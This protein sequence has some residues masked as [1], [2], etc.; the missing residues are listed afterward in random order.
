MP[1]RP[2]PSA[3][4]LAL[5]F[6][7]AG[8][9]LAAAAGATTIVVTTDADADAADGGCSLREAILAANDD[10]A[11]NECPAGDGPDRIEFSLTLPEIIVLT[12]HLP[13]I[14]GT[15]AI[16]GPGATLLTVDGDTTFRPLD[17]DSPG[18]D[19]WLLVE[20]LAFT[21]GRTPAG[22]TT[23]GG[24]HIGA[25]DT[26]T[27][28]RVRFVGNRAE[29]GGGGLAVDSH[30]AAQS[31]TTLVDCLVAENVAEGPAGG[32]GLFTG[33]TG[34]VVRIVGTTFFANEAAHPNGPGGGLRT[35]RAVVN[36]LDSTLT[37]NLA[38]GPGGGLYVS[39]DPIGGSTLVIRNT[40]IVDNQAGTQ[41]SSG[42]GGGLSARPGPDFPLDLLIQ[43]TV[44]AENLD[45]TGVAPDLDCGPNLTTLWASGSDFVGSDAGCEALFPPGEPNAAGDF[46]GT[47]TAPLLPLLEILAYHGGPTPTHRPSV[48]P[49]SP[50]ID[51]GAC[52]DAVA[53]QRGHGDP[54]AH[55]RPVDA[56]GAP[57]I[58]GGDDCDIGA[59]ERLGQAGAAP[60]IFADGFELGHTLLWT[61]EV[62]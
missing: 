55:R 7:L 52:A 51:Q 32:G 9:S 49:L 36:L 2:R 27:F 11:H 56:P 12:D 31:N 22:E 17:L 29:N 41:S 58:T 45:P 23:G 18:D 46:V 38:G 35:T 28:R 40:T 6:V 3:A 15:L 39:T 26:A 47:P 48:S 62:R 33:G 5:A 4:R 14:T 43:N 60:E 1:A 25:G 8:W 16:R 42:H 24:A 30:S 61:R 53:D 10:R 20:D 57:G 50:L 34:N 37:A 44:V 21:H 19:A 13:T 54:V 59:F